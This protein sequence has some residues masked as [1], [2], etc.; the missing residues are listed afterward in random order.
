MP[1]IIELLMGG[2]KQ[3]MI[4]RSLIRKKQDRYEKYQNT[5]ITMSVK[6]LAKKF[7]EYGKIKSSSQFLSLFGIALSL[8]FSL[9]SIDFTTKYKSI[10]WI[11]EGI[12]VLTTIFTMLSFRAL[13]MN[14]RSKTPKEMSIST[15][16]DQYSEVEHTVI[17]IVK[18]T[19]EDDSIR[20]LT[21]NHWGCSFLPYT[22]YDPKR[23]IKD[24]QKELIRNFCEPLNIKEEMVEIIDLDS[25][26]NDI[27]RHAKTGQNALFEY[28][29]YNVKISR[30]Y[31]AHLFKKTEFKI[32]KKKFMWKRI[33]GL[34]EEGTTV[35]K[36]GDVIN[37]IKEVLDVNN[38][39][40][41]MEESEG[42]FKQKQL[43]V[44]WNITDKCA[45]SCEICGTHNELCGTKNLSEDELKH[46]LLSLATAKDCIGSLDFSGGD[47]LA[48]KSTMEIIKYSKSIFDF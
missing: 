33:D 47:P 10:I 1:M 8:W 17:F 7:E 24:Q 37:H 38:L 40:N 32:N 19:F 2:I 14:V 9:L 41:A 13:F 39:E 23:D 12:I 16:D 26:K 5:I 36:N 25:K 34:L 31:Y 43:K 46:C 29:F 21:H 18:Q 11:R 15:M 35:L 42:V 6:D 20:I 4:T 28:R 30:T 3:Q 27:K 45:F 48:D 44:I 22:K